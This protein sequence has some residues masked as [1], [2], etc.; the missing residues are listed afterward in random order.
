MALFAVACGDD[1]SA[2]ATDP[3]SSD[4]SGDDDPG[5]DAAP[6][7]GDASDDADDGGGASGDGGGSAGP[8]DEATTG[9]GDTGGGGDDGVD[10]PH[11]FV[12]ETVSGSMI[13]AGDFAGQDLVLW[14]WAPW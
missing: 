6:D 1:D 13:D 9:G 10:W 5:S 2:T 8:G 3:G 11:D 7:D 12:A 14:F 4:A